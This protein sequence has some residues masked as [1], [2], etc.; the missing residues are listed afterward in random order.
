MKTKIILF[1]VLLTFPV[2]IQAQ[3][4]DSSLIVWKAKFDY[5]LIEDCLVTNDNK[6]VLVSTSN[7]AKLLLVDIS[8][9]EIVREFKNTFG[10]QRK[11]KMTPDGTKVISLLTYS[12]FFGGKSVIIWDYE[13]GD[14]LQKIN[15][16]NSEG[17]ND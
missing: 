9:G 5:G 13:S 7:P 14:T 8:N 15:A 6:Y 10:P 17:F 4:L 12:D 11:L 2:F 16:I 3:E 1:L